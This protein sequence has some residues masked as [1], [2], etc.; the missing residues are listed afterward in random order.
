M[1]ITSVAGKPK[2]TLFEEPPLSNEGLREFELDE[3]EPPKFICLL[4]LS[5]NS[6]QKIYILFNLFGVS[7]KMSRNILK[8]RKKKDKGHYFS[9]HFWTKMSIRYAKENDREKRKR[10]RERER[11][12][13]GE[14]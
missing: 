6:K 5:Y 10:R 11:K 13:E 4:S 3:D 14:I 12:L 9:R 2:P 8:C 7:K 1:L